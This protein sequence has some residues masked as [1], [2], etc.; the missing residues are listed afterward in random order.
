MQRGPAEDGASSQPITL[1]NLTETVSPR[2]WGRS[3]VGTAPESMR[4]TET[5]GDPRQ[6]KTGADKT[7][8]GHQENQGEGARRGS[9]TQCAPNSCGM[10]GVEAIGSKANSLIWGAPTLVSTQHK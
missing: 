1:G 10:G 5:Q 2:H 6:Q 8:Q 3:Q 9:E 4:Q 7:Q